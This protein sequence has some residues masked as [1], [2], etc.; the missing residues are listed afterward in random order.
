LPRDAKTG[1]LVAVTFDQ[2]W[3]RENLLELR[4]I[5]AS[6]L[7]LRLLWAGRLKEAEAMAENEK[8]PGEGKT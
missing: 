2:E 5:N 3:Q 7:M 8:Q 4:K 1:E 6:L